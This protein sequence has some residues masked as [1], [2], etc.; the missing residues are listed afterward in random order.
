M[1]AWRQWVAGIGG[2]WDVTAGLCQ[3]RLVQGGYHRSVRRREQPRKAIEDGIEQGMWIPRA[4]REQTIVGTP[5]QKLAAGGA[6]GVAGQMGGQ[7][8]EQ[9]VSQA[10]RTLPGALLRRVGTP[11]L[12]QFIEFIQEE[13]HGRMRKRALVTRWQRLARRAWSLHPIK[14]SRGAIFQAALVNSRQASTS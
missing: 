12:Q 11:G 5:I 2:A 4:A 8:K 10:V 1:N 7:A 9:T 3:E 13:E 14:L 6:N